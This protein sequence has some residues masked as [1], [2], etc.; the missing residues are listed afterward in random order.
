MHRLAA[1]AASATAHAAR[2]NIGYTPVHTHQHNMS[3]MSHHS[4][5]PTRPGGMEPAHAAAL[6][7]PPMLE[8]STYSEWGCQ[9]CTAADRQ[10]AGR[11]V[12]EVGHAHTRLASSDV[13]S[14]PQNPRVL[15]SMRVSRIHLADCSQKLVHRPLPARDAPT[16]ANAAEASAAKTGV[17]AVTAAK[18][19]APEQSAVHKSLISCR[20]V[21]RATTHS[22][23][24]RI[25]VQ[26]KGAT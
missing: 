10:Q 13:A 8:A 14:L 4:S 20:T 9:H 11:P 25:R 16:K 7:L 5:V 3:L 22:T 6:L 2:A 12:L 17:L 18:S 24:N 21:G 19:P 26:S 23:G 15:Q 1:Q